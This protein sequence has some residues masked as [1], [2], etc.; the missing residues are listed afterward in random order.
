[1]MRHIPAALRQQVIERAHD[2]CEYCGLSQEGQAAKFHI[3]H[4]V[5]LAMDGETSLD[6]LALACVSC[7]LHKGAR[8]SLTDPET[9]QETTVFNPR[10][11]MWSDHFRWDG[12]RLAGL[13]PVGRA[14]IDAL[15]MN[16]P[17]IVAIRAEEAF[18]NRHPPPPSVP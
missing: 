2:R 16:R 13:T 17:V 14:T 7:S 15:R 9:G 5:P 10:Q 12:T 18:F 11:E 4:V 6:N 3:D 8:Q 1:M